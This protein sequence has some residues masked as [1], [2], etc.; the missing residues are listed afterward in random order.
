MTP[1][2]T[3]SLGEGKARN[4]P[5]LPELARLM[6]TIPASSAQLERFLSG[7]ELVVTEEEDRTGW[8]L[9]IWRFIPL[10]TVWPIIENRKKKGK[11]AGDRVGRSAS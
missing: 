2:T 6:L 3:L 9:T 1:S 4:L 5:L 7:P 8:V 10:R 11:I